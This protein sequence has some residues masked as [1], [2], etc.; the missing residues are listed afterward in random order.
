MGSALKGTQVVI[1]EEEVEGGEEEEVVT[2]EE[3][4]VAGEARE[5]ATARLL[6]SISFVLTKA[7]LVRK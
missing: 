5:A 3:E 7:E 6:C 4:V 1:R 2:G